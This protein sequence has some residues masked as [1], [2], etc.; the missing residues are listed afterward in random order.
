M[1][2]AG[3]A[4]AMM[5]AMVR[6]AMMRPVVRPAMMRP[7]VVRPVMRPYAIVVM[8]SRPIDADMTGGNVR[9]LGNAAR[10]AERGKDERRLR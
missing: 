1:S 6:P 10:K 2:A 8:V 9:S 7:V 3:A 4:G 5:T